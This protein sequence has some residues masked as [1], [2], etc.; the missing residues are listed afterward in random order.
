MSRLRAFDHDVG[1]DTSEPHRTNTR[2][3][4]QV[5]RPRP[6]VAYD[7]KC[8][9]KVLEDFAKFAKENK[10][11]RG[12]QEKANAAGQKLGK[13]LVEAGVDTK[14]LMDT[15]SELAK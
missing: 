4:V 3:E 10:N 2:P 7:A 11:A 6:T 9:D 12:D 1:V 5:G 8:A 15:L 13:C 14:K